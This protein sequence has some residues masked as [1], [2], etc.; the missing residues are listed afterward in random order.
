MLT[1]TSRAAR[2]SLQS[3][4]PRHNPM[5]VAKVAAT[6]RW[7]RN[8]P[9][10]PYDDPRR[11]PQPFKFHSYCPAL[12]EILNYE[13]DLRNVHCQYFNRLILSVDSG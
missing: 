3:R 8:N 4:V 11:P 10:R 5:M 9:Q 12:F 1:P 2:S 13:L 7:P 6:P